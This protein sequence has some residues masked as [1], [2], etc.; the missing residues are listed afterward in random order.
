VRSGC[1]AATMD[2]I[3]FMDS[4]GQFRVEDFELLLPHVDSFAFVT[5]RRRKRA[6]SL[7]RNVYGKMLG[8]LIWTTLTIWVRDINCAMK[9]FKRSLWPRIRP[10]HGTEKFFN[11]EIFLN[12]KQQNIL[13]YQVDVSHYPRRSGT[14][15][16][17][18]LRVILKMFSELW[19][20]K[21]AKPHLGRTNL[22][23]RGQSMQ[24]KSQRE[25]NALR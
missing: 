4:D 22:F 21:R 11:A 7:I 13:W 18:S 9:V 24:R 5:G 10:V 6:D 19:N 14:P 17:A 3:A 8:L 15:T 23:V 16:G 20:L 12:L 25:I 1:D 2:L